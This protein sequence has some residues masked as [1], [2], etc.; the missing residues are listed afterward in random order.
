LTAPILSIDVGWAVLSV[1]VFI[2]GPS[3][4]SNSLRNSTFRLLNLNVIQMFKTYLFAAVAAITLSSCG[5]NKVTVNEETITLEDGIYAKL[6]TTMGDILI[7]FHEDLAPMTAANFIA[8]SE[9][10][11]PEVDEKYAGLPYYN[12]TLFHRVIKTL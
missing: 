3:W 12:G 2:I 5:G 4:L 7:D 11:H 9:G 8:L 10:N 6:E 1:K